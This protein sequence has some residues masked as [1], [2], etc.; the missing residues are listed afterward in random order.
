[1]TDLRAIQASFAGGE[2][3]PAV[4]ARID[5]AKYNSALAVC[6]NFEIRPHGGAATRP[7][8]QFVAELKDSSA[9]G[10]LIPFAFSTTQTYVLAWE[11]LA[12]RV[13]KDAGLVLEDAVAI[14]GATAADP[15]VISATA[16][17]FANGDEVYIQAVV[18]MTELN[19]RRFIVANKTDNDFELSGV[20][21]EAYTAYDSAGTVSRIFTLVSPYATASL[22]LVKYTQSADVM[23][24]VHTSH[25]VRELT[26]T[27]HDAWTLTTVTFAPDQAHPTAITC[28]PASGASTTYRYQ[29]TAVSKE[30]GEES[31]PGTSGSAVVISGATKANPVVITATSHGL[32]NGDEVLISGVVGMTEL[33]GQRVV[34][35]NKDTN[36]FE[37]RGV[38]GTNYT[39]YSSA[40]S[41]LRTYVQITNGASPQNNTVAFTEAAGA[42]SYNIYRQKNGIY[43][44]VGRTETASF[45]DNNLDADIEDTPPRFRNPFIGT[46]NY[47]GTVGYYEQR[48]ILANS[49]NKPQTV[50]T[51]QTGNYKNLSVSSPTK[52]DDAITF[53]IAAQQVNAVRHVVP[54]SSMVLLTSG[55]EW[56]VNSGDGA[57]TPSNISLKPQGYRGA[58]DIPPLII[59]NTVLYV[60]RGEIVRDL[61]YTFESDSFTGNDLSVLARHMFDGYEIMA[62]AYAQSPDSIV[63]AVRSDGTLLGFTY[64]REHQVWAWHRHVTDG[65]FESVAVITEGNEDAVYVIVRR[66]VGGAT[67]RFI[68]RLH[69]RVFDSIEDAFCVDSGKTLDEPIAI[70]AASV[71]STTHKV[72]VTAAGHG[73]ANDDICDI[74]G[75]LGMTEINGYGWIVSDRTDDTFILKDVDGFV[76]GTD[77]GTYTSG[78]NVRE[79]VTTFGGLEHLAGRTDVVALAN[80]NVVKDL[81]VSATGTV[82]LPFPAS[83][84][85]AGLL[86]VPEL[87]T[88]KVE[89]GL[90]DG[91]LQGRHKSIPKVTMRV[92]GS[93]GFWIGPNRDDMVEA[94]WRSTEAYAE[95]TRMITGDVSVILPSSRNTDGKFVVQQRDPLPLTILAV[96]PEVQIGS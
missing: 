26:R 86:Y 34:V 59:G 82:T 76:D 24:L 94:K 21:G 28:T 17:G 69:S 87:E 27:D 9:L 35:A 47:P 18:G 80:G 78:G 64:L 49:T 65:Y 73:L 1:M 50:W 22:P 33:N 30:T 72:T 5:L 11:N 43:G 67:K 79:A 96:I 19:G 23:T 61:T 16:H 12:M 29:V 36:T 91:T 31:L 2:V 60:Q 51:T 40:G 10:R 53:T 56:R 13:V 39:T 38:D 8:F 63:W 25:M 95:P 4:A 66:T 52:D 15:V 89:V 71:H 68:E 58:T 75:V 45:V 44:W 88:L 20:D 6:E 81:T 90:R 42:A 93:R 46:G 74:E 37:C 54:L 41:A 7:G 3:S 92:E 57:M 32:A 84:I 14:A 83:R 77:F 48:L 85:H 55:G 62:W 70:T